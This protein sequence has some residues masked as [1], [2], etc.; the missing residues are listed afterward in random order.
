MEYREATTSDGFPYA[1]KCGDDLSCVT[2]EMFAAGS[3]VIELHQEAW[4][5]AYSISFE[6]LA[7]A[8]E[9]MRRLDPRNECPRRSG[10]VE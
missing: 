4:E 9:A 2:Y 6:A 3:R 7:G 8:Y 1:A 10:A 5:E